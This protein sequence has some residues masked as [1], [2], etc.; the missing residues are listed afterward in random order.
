MTL[1]TK[2][3][4]MAIVASG[5]SREV[6]D[7]STEGLFDVTA[8]RALAPEVGELSNVPL[9]LIVDHLRTKHVWEQ[10]RV[11]ELTPASYLHDP[12]IVVVYIENGEEVHLLIDGT[13]RALRRHHEGYV[14]MD[15][16]FISSKHIIRPSSDWEQRKD[17]DWG[18]EHKDGKII[19]RPK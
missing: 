9:H 2:S 16:W 6:F 13:H 17:M 12:G 18:D 8:M 19:R 3:E 10:A 1:R 15:F 14:N 5:R 4:L 7:H 11:D